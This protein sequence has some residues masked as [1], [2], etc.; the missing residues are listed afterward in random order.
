MCCIG[1]FGRLC[2]AANSNVCRTWWL[3]CLQTSIE[4]MLSLEAATD[5]N[6]DQMASNLGGKDMAMTTNDE[7]ILYGK[8]GNDLC[9]WKLVPILMI[10]ILLNGTRIRFR[11][12]ETK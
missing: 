10:Q 5:D 1:S 8:C 4:T 7:V 3:T 2:L 12:D 6:K 9:F 11:I